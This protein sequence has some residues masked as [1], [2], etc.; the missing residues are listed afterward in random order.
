MSPAHAGMDRRCSPIG[1]YVPGEPRA[2]GD[3]PTLLT[4]VIGRLL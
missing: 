3:G 2:R 4:D 1:R